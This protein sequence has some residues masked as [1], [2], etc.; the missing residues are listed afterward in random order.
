MNTDYDSTCT[1]T[2]NYCITLRNMII[3]KLLQL[4]WVFF[5]LLPFFLHGNSCHEKNEKFVL[6]GRPVPVNC[7]NNWSD[8]H[9]KLT[10]CCHDRDFCN[11]KLALTLAPPPSTTPPGST[12]Y[13]VGKTTRLYNLKNCVLFCKT[14]EFG[15]S[16]VWVTKLMGRC[17][18]LGTK[19]A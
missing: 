6:D 5:F 17:F 1:Y 11:D 16:D 13:S 14:L 4:S 10:E 7:L 9:N 19:R 3:I 18:L 8:S 12:M 15:H 2:L